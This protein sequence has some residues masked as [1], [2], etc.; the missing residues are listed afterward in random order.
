MT[1]DSAAFNRT[2][3]ELNSAF[4][5][6]QADGGTFGDLPEDL[7][8]EVDDIFRKLLTLSYGWTGKELEE[9]MAY[10]QLYCA[11]EAKWNEAAE[12]YKQQA[13]L[14]LFFNRFLIKIFRKF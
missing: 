14:L 10:L 1:F 11:P 4:Q 3:E 2:I 8:I 7:Q 5:A 13:M 12:V 9:R 6:F